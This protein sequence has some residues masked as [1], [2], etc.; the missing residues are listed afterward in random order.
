MPVFFDAAATKSVASGLAPLALLA[1]LATSSGAVADDDRCTGTLCDL[2]YAAR[3]AQPA[4]SAAQQATTTQQQA[5]PVTVPS[6]GGILNF[7]KSSPAASASTPAAPGAPA[8]KPFVYFTEGTHYDRCTGTLCDVYYGSSSA[9]PAGQQ[10]ASTTG[11]ATVP[12]GAAVTPAR[13]ALTA[14]QV[15]LAKAMQQRRAAQEAHEQAKAKCRL[16]G[17]SDLWHCFR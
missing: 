2:Y 14:E 11:S 6:S 7:F 16:A 5:T 8:A 13:P 15:A 4:S 3:P 1:L 9:K 12:A 17:G 10:Q